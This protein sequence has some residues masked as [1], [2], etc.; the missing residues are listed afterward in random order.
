MA[1]VVATPR[2]SETLAFAF[3]H[4]YAVTSRWMPMMKRMSPRMMSPVRWA[5]SSASCS[6]P[7]GNML[8]AVEDIEFLTPVMRPEESPVIPSPIPVPIP[9]DIS[10]MIPCGVDVVVELVPVV[11]V[12]LVLVP[13]VLELLLD[14]VPNR[15]PSRP[16]KMSVTNVPRPLPM[17]EKM[18]F[19]AGV[20]DVEELELLELA[21]PSGVVLLLVLVLA[22]E[23]VL[24]V[25][26]AWALAGV[27]AIVPQFLT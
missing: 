7:P 14:P 6:N 1:S 13:P 11:L 26:V 27:L 3:G 17:S 16:P 4:F 20:D 12:P 25:V 24:V 8:L 19:I 2:T 9:V 21:A 5:N 22:V 18:L 15:P 23:G 10:P